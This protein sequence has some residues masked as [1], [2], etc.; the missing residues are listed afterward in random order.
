MYYERDELTMLTTE[1]A[2]LLVIDFQERLMPLI[3]RY[4]EL[5]RK[6]AIMIKGC[7]VLDVPIIVTQQYTKGLGETIK[8]LKDSFGGLFDPIEK[9]TFSCCGNAVF[10]EALKSAGMKKIIVTGVE[11]HICVQQTVL[12]LLD[13]GYPV[14]V[15]ADCVGSRS[16]I[17]FSI[18]LK[19]ME[20]A[21]AIITTMESILFEM[22]VSADHPKRKA[23]SE[24]VK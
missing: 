14:Y 21:G 7:R 10:S 15:I 24:L 20:N 4:E 1:N 13:R 19:R 6:S 11:T 9:L 2:L 3:D 18:A 17:D 23:I 8:E 16:E 5:E 22:L 12:D